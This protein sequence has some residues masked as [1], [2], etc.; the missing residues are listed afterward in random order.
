VCIS[1]RCVATASMFKG[2]AA[3]ASTM[4]FDEVGDRW[5]SVVVAPG[6]CKGAQTE[7]W[8]VFSLQ[9]RPDGTL[10]GEHTRATA[11]QC[12][13]KRTVTF[14]RTG[15]VDVDADFYALPDPAGL[16]PRVVS[17]AE[18]LRGNYHVTRTFTTP[19]LPVMQAD[20]AVTTDCLRTGDRCMSYFSV[21]SGDIPLLF[22]GTKFTST[23]RSQNSCP[24][25]GLSNLATDAQYPL[26]QPPQDPIQGLSGHGTWVQTGTCA[27]N[28]EFDETFTRTG[29]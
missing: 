2:D 12:A 5:L 26:P 11:D 14:T 7:T 20:T 21:A 28:L 27:V 3:F 4:V 8:Q 19:G 15:D 23:E 9:P 22:D 1:D 16:P 10:T 29:D 6:Q 13:E 18:A 25:G 24:S 17:P